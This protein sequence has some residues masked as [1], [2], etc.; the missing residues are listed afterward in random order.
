M[1]NFLYSLADFFAPRPVQRRVSHS[2]RVT[3]YIVIEAMNDCGE[4]RYLEVPKPLLLERRENLEVLLTKCKRLLSFVTKKK[5]D[6]ELSYK[7]IDLS[8]RVRS[9]M[10]RNDDITPLFDDFD[11]FEKMIKKS[12]KSCVNLS[13]VEH[14]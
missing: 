7:V 5:C 2:E 6:D 13:S 12:S 4:K 9:A 11:I 10:Y 14:L 1:Q 8:E 3:K